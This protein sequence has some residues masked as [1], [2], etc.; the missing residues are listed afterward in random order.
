MRDHDAGH[1]EFAA[2]RRAASGHPIEQASAT[3]RGLMPW[4]KDA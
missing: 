2:W 4:L 3:V 1:P